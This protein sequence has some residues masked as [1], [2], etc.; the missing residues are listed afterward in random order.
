MC[1]ILLMGFRTAMDNG[2]GLGLREQGE[3]MKRDKQ[4]IAARKFA[5]GVAISA[6]ILA[7]S[8]GAVSVSARQGQ[9][10]DAPPVMN[11]QAPPPNTTPPV[12]GRMP[13]ANPA[14]NQGDRQAGPAVTENDLHVI[15]RTRELLDSA[16]KWNRADS[17]TCEQNAG[18]YSLECALET[19][20]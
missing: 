5:G 11:Q 6:A 15:Q 7:L 12:Q 4:C 9:S 17:Q 3:H 8:F 16:R 2:T 13:N 19:A 14:Y 18:T 1:R 20:S 10:Q